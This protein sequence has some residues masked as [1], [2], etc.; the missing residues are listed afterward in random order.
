[1]ELACIHSRQ[2]GRDNH[3]LK[4]APTNPPTCL[5][6]ISCYCSLIHQFA[7]FCHLVK[8]HC[9]MMLTQPLSLATAN[10]TLARHAHW[11]QKNRYAIVG[12]P[13]AIFI[14]SFIYLKVLNCLFT[15]TFVEQWALYRFSLACWQCS[16]HPINPL[17]VDWWSVLSYVSNPLHLNWI[18]YLFFVWQRLTPSLATVSSLPIFIWDCLCR[19]SCQ[20]ARW[21]NP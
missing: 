10:A 13:K 1:M 15:I 9:K 2:M 4:S 7:I 16:D 14:S 21:L 5:R 11:A 12:P 6:C 3:Q 20:L 17:S 19:F 18:F 8:T